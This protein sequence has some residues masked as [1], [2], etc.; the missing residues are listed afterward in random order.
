MRTRGRA[1]TNHREKGR[2][3]HDSVFN[4]RQT[5]YVRREH[6]LVATK[7]D[8]DDDDDDDDD[9]TQPSEGGGRKLRTTDDDED[10]GRTDN[11]ALSQYG[12]KYKIA[13]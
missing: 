1:C 5:L 7:T 3:R 12:N 8:N 13:P 10:E 9:Q 11:E 2:T 4:G 6:F